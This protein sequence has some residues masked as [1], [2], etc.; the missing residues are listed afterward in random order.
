MNGGVKVD[1]EWLMGERGGREERAKAEI[2]D[3]G[4]GAE[5][6]EEIPKWIE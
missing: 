1:E 3:R 6:R 4:E 2:E 5:G